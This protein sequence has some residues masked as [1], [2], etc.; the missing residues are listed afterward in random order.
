MGRGTISCVAVVLVD[1]REVGGKV[2]S[3]LK[4]LTRLDHISR[5]VWTHVA[6]TP[7]FVLRKVQGG[8]AISP[9]PLVCA[10]ANECL[11]QAW[12]RR[13]SIGGRCNWP[14]DSLDSNRQSI[15]P[16]DA[17]GSLLARLH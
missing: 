3:L 16:A 5:E 7:H 13:V 2:E 12:S 17:V 1:V 11:G 6:F 10:G 15:V 4:P 8:S 9:N 14:E